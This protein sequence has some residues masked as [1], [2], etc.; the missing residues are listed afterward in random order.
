MNWKQR[1]PA[2]S[3]WATNDLGSDTRLLKENDTQSKGD[4]PK[5]PPME[6]TR[7]EFVCE[8]F[9]FSMGTERKGERSNL[10]RG[11]QQ[12]SEDEGGR[13]RQAERKKN[14]ALHGRSIQARCDNGAD[15]GDA[16]CQA[17]ILV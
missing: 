16:P 2:K 13:D 15:V 12:R 17:M 7:V 6:V 11:V 5:K 10:F 1:A 14:S 8:K 4:S 3:N 9:T